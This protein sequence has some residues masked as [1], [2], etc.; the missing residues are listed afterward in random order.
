M[1][2]TASRA[3]LTISAALILGGLACAVYVF[4]EWLGPKGGSS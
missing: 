3:I 1:L 4:F 2:D